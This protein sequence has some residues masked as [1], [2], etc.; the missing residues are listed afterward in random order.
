MILITESLLLEPHDN[1]EP[2]CDEIRYYIGHMLK[3]EG[4]TSPPDVLRIAMFDALAESARRNANKLD[5]PLIDPL[6]QIASDEPVMTLRN[7]AAQALGALN[8]TTNKASEIIRKY[9]LK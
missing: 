5:A 8:L 2:F 4:F 3:E 7:A 6:I 1:P 9:H